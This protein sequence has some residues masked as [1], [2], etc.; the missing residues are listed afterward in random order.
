MIFV[1]GGETASGKSSL[2]FR[3]AQTINGIIIN[4]DAFAF[5]RELNIGTA[6]PSAKELASVP[7]F[8]FN[9]ISVTDTYSIYAYQ[10]DG[11]AIIDEYLKRNIPI[12]IVGGSG[13]YLRAL[14]YDYKLNEETIETIDDITISNEALYENLLRLDKEAATKIHP[15]NRKR[16]LRALTI[17]KSQKMTKSALDAQTSK[18][19]LYPYVMVTLTSEKSLLDQRIVNRTK[20]MFARGLKAEA[21]ALGAHYDHKLQALQAIGYKEILANENLSDTELI[22]LI[23]LRTRQLAKRQRTF[24]KNQFGSTWFPNAD[25]AYSYLYGKYEEM[26]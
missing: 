23:S 1:I 14:L 6:K 11:R 26:L 20:T 8:L 19:P 12:I 13:L 4:A 10:K 22:E 9:N 24:F 2:A 7:C 15:N 5:Y 25:D 21:L 16:V 17:A 3:L 18:D